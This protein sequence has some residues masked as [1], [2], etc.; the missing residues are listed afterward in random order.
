MTTDRMPPMAISTLTSPKLFCPCCVLT[1]LSNSRLAGMT[2][3]RIVFKSGSDDACR[4]WLK[5][6]TANVLVVLVAAADVC[7]ISWNFV[8][9]MKLNV[10]LC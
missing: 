8:N 3:F 9:I 4:L 7:P 2:S 1:F 10:H 5:V 6:E